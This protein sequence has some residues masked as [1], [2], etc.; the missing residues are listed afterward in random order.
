MRAGRVMTSTEGRLTVRRVL[1]PLPLGRGGLTR[2]GGRSICGESPDQSRIAN[3]GERMRQGRRNFYINSPSDPC[4]D[5][6]PSPACAFLG[7]PRLGAIPSAAP[8]ERA[9]LRFCPV[10]CATGSGSNPLDIS[11]KCCIV[12]YLLL[13]RPFERLSVFSGLAALNFSLHILYNSF[14]SSH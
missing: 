10:L 13:K 4:P 7:R 2:R 9:L 14:A 1:N 11:S 8:C 3:E 12:M 5:L 6:H